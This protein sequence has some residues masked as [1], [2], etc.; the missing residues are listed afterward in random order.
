MLQDENKPQL[1]SSGSPY[2][3]AAEEKYHT[4]ANAIGNLLS[5]QYDALFS[6]FKKLVEKDY[7]AT[8]DAW[9]MLSSN[10]RVS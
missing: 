6:G 5:P 8:N 4:L 7:A 3:K 1:S 10:V 9:L 2:L